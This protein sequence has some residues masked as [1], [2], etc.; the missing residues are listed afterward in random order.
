MGYLSDIVHMKTV[1]VYGHG[2]FNKIH[3]MLIK[4]RIKSGQKVRIFYSSDFITSLRI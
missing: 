4:S 1:I 2:S 3:R